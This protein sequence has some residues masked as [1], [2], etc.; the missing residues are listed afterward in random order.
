MTDFPLVWHPKV[1]APAPAQGE[2]SLRLLDMPLGQVAASSQREA[3]RSSFAGGAR[4]ARGSPGGAAPARRRRAR[5]EPDQPAR[6]RMPMIAT[7]CS[8][9]SAKATSGRQVGGSVAYEIAESVLAGLWRI[10]ATAQ[11]GTKSEWLEVADIPQAIV[12]TAER[13][14]REAIAIP[15]RSRR[16]R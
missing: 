6:P 8:T 12:A 9:S 11:D 2:D 15:T 4:S 5:A 16:A 3:G 14:P 13:M 7:W 1:P 10:E